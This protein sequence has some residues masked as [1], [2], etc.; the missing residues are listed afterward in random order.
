[1]SGDNKLNRHRELELRSIQLHRA[2]ALKIALE[3]AIIESTKNEI[4]TLILKHQ[5]ST[6]YFLKW[7]DI[8]SHS[9]SFIQE[10]LVED[11]EEMATL[12]Q[13]SPFAGVLNPRERWEIY[14]TFRT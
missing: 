7:L 3:P 6:K 9:L 11:S 13:S 10:K 2:V 12:R 4:S 8:L 1:M 14:E 5:E